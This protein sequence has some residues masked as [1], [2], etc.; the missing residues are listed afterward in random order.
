M[1]HILFSLR[2]LIANLCNW[3]TFV[4]TEINLCDYLLKLYIPK[5]CVFLIDM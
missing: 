5:E 4:Y 1:K 2:H 3:V